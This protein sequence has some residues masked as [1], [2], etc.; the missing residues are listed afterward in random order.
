MQFDLTVSPHALDGID[1]GSVE[2]LRHFALGVFAPRIHHARLHLERRAQ[3]DGV[4]ARL[5]VRLI[6]GLVVEARATAGDAASCVRQVMIRAR[7]ALH[8][9][10]GPAARLAAR[11]HPA[12]ARAGAEPAGPDGGR[13]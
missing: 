6:N 4:D 11:L 7:R 8:R 12:V 9:R 2:R 13:R 10:L 1:H 5:T 3:G